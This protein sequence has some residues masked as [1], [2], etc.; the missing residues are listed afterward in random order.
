[1]DSGKWRGSFF[2]KKSQKIAQSALKI[3]DMGGTIRLMGRDR[4]SLG[5][6]KLKTFDLSLVAN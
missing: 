4:P 5:E 2:V 3:R 6:T 1:M